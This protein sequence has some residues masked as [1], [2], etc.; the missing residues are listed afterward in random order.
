MSAAVSCRSF[1]YVPGDR[2]DR[3]AKAMASSAHAVIVDLEDAVKPDAKPAARAALASMPARTSGQR[4]VRINAGAD[5][6]ADLAALG[7]IEVAG[8]IDGLVLAK[9]E[10][11]VWLDE[12]AAAVPPSVALAPLVE[13]ARAVRSLDAIVG[14]PRVQQC[15]LEVDLLADLGGRTPGGA[16]LVRHV[17]IE[18]VIA[19]AAA[20]IAAPIGGVHLAIDDLDA[21]ARSS[22]EL[23]ELGFA[24]RRRPPAPLRRGERGVRTVRAGAC[25]GRGRAGPLERRRPRCAA[26]RRR[27]DDRRSRRATRSSPPRLTAHPRPSRSRSVRCRWAPCPRR[28][29]RRAGRAPRRRSRR[30]RR[31]LRPR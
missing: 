16:T 20:G 17:R 25:V 5:G 15:Q 7:S 4:W 22:R 11:T 26:R 31:A 8:G 13:T 10:N 9:C 28:R 24:G 6:R 14:H 18:L 3:V 2:A 21:L 29:V 30:W 27:R 23:A 1:L 19:S 12:V